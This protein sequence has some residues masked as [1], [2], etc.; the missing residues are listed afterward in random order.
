MIYSCVDEPLDR[1]MSSH[2]KQGD[3]LPFIPTSFLWK[4]NI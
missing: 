4:K 1:N 3:A 2:G